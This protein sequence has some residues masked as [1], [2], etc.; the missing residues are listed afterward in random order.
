MANAPTSGAPPGERR[1]LGP[2]TLVDRIAVGGMA[3][4]FR[5]LEPRAAGEPRVVVLKRMLPHVAAE[6]GS[7]AMF[8]EEADL[9]A[10]VKHPN[11]VHVLELGESDGQ[12]YL[13][14]E[15]VPG[16]DLWR[17]SRFL[18]R[19]GQPLARE[20][21]IYIVLDL[22]RG[23][24]AVH[25]ATDVD[26]HPLRIIHRDV[27][28][29]NVLLSTR[30]EV[31]LGDFGIARGPK[32]QP[33]RPAASSAKAKG[34]IGYLAPEQ[35]VGAPSDQRAD[36]FAAGVIAAELLM[37]AP[38]FS[39]SSELAVLLA[40]RDARIERFA[41]T[42]AELPLPLAAAIRHALSPD[43]EARMQSAAAFAEKIAPFGPKDEDRTRR[44][45]GEL[46]TLAHRATTD[47]TTA[48]EPAIATADDEP[49]SPLLSLE[50]SPTTAELPTQPY[51]AL[52]E[53][54]GPLGTFTFAQLVEAIATG[55]LG[56]HDRV[57]SGDDAPKPIAE[58]ALLS[59]HLPP[60]TFTPITRESVSPIPADRR[61]SIAEGGIVRALVSTASAAESGLWLC[62]NE[63]A[64]KEIYVR[65]GKLDLVASNQSSELLGEYL[66]SRGVLSRGELDMAL[67][68]MPRFEGR[69]GDTLVALGLIES[70]DLFQHIAEQGRQKLL[71]LF[72]WPEGV[73]SF[74][75]NAPTPP[76]GFPLGIDPWPLLDEG[77]ALRLARGL[78]EAT[79]RIHMLDSLAQTPAASELRR[80]PGV[81]AT[82][83]RAL[84][85][86]AGPT[87][88]HDVVAAVEAESDGTGYRTVV[89]LLHLEALRWVGT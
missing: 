17:L 89:L 8:R 52:G 13:V 64:R 7:A 47:A 19:Q 58:L 24:S 72:L 62:E 65:D 55:R 40:I 74:Y 54:G 43:P 9:G 85:A 67:A 4:V 31:K 87:H 46:V 60:S 66:V 79:F 34:K 42:A 11:V 12:P 50:D 5:A 73:A 29:S 23:L 39:G 16:C 56:P 1:Q 88:L 36:I 28:P 59:R 15:Y 45:L 78:E 25:G 63:T 2:Y 80:A 33:P 51:I 61:Y 69:I 76:S 81:P 30:G 21:A 3:E 77:V 71:D 20:I 18:R 57:V 49:T 32:A 70:V 22:L 6:P 10:R 27:S 14:L 38:L 82:V 68:V 83:K 41:E 35:V 53:D 48:S 26:G 44:A 84:E 86:T 37:G 75:R